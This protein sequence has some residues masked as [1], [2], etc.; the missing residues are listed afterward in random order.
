MDVLRIFIRA[1]PRRTALVVAGLLLAGLAEGIGL[2]SFVP[3]IGLVAR[4]GGA[5]AAGDS[6]L[7]RAVVMALGYV[8]LQPTSGVLLA[9]I[10]AAMTVKAAL[11][12]LASKQVGY[13]VARLATDVRLTLLRAT[14]ASRWERY[15]HWP[16]GT[17][18]GAFAAEANRAAEAYLRAAT[19][20][21][22]LIQ[23]L[24]YAG[25]AVL[26]SWRATVAALAASVVVVALLN[27]LI[28]AARRAGVRQ[29]R[30][31]RAVLGRLTDTLQGVKSLKAMGRES[32]VAPLLEAE[33]RQLNRA[34]ER[35]VL[36]KAAMRAFQEPLIVLLLALGLYAALTVMALPLA[37]VV[38]LTLLCVRIITSLGK[39][40]KEY[41]HLAACE[42][43]FAAIREL[44]Q[45]AEAAREA[46]S[47]GRTPALTRELRLV[48]V[49]FAYGDA[50]VVRG[51]SLVAPA[52]SVTAVTGPS[53]SGK[54][55]V[56]DLLVGLLVPQE[57]E[58]LVD[59]V[60]LRELEVGAWRAMVGYVPQETLLWHD[61]I[62]RNVSLGDPSVSAA[63][64]QAA[65]TAAGAWEFVGGLADGVETVV[66]ERGLRVSGGQR[67]RIALARA[68]VR[69][70]RLLVLDEATSALDP[71]SE[72]AIVETVRGLRD[73]MTIVAVCHRGPLLAVADRAYRV[74]GGAI[75]PLVGPAGGTREE[76]AAGT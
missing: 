65:L 74:E 68:L 73:R 40:Q 8:G 14:L 13:A 2:S 57:G 61:T 56:V 75:V 25:V 63:D 50:W 64:V 43:A 39:V 53:G 4:N 37:S 15:V 1:D 16:V 6:S 69:R 20:A 55:T 24:V 67:Q 45:Q 17:F 47:G 29:T 46:P 22:L 72:A 32:L 66:G 58:V 12:L 70:P 11:D 10:V 42:G 59:G 71:A 7:E 26:V 52:G 62:A 31:A 21:A 35:E 51:A 54:T 60:P 38:L 28:R 3:L 19:M 48:D 30:L 76:S 27:G 36:S 41:Q 23:A 9:L 34:L 33:T 18:A 49:G 44:I 5:A